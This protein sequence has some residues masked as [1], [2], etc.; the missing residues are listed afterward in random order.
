MNTKTSKTQKGSKKEQPKEKKATGK[1]AMVL[2]MV[3]KGK[4]R[5]EILDY[6]VGLDKDISRKSNAGLVSHIFKAYDL[7]GKV[8]SGVER[9]NG[10]KKKKITVAKKESK[11]KAAPKAQP[12]AEKKEEANEA[13][14]F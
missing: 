2:Q 13:N 11:P 4:T 8:D 3:E 6:L 10:G 14:E 12:K 9:T 1:T 5:K 7:L